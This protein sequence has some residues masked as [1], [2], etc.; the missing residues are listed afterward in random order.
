MSSTVDE[1]VVAC[2][3]EVLQVD[4]EDVVPDARFTEDLGA[5][6]LMLVELVMAL[7]ETYG[8]SV[9]EEQMSGIHTV[10]NLCALLPPVA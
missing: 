7:E 2:V 10:E 4:A 1:Q 8:I 9:S 5:S 3:V 6:S